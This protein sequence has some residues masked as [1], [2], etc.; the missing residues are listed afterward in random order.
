MTP[1][2]PARNRDWMAKRRML[3]SNMRG[4]TMRSCPTSISA[5][6][7]VMSCALRGVAEEGSI[8]LL[9]EEG[10][11]QRQHGQHEGGTQQVWHAEQAQLGVGGFDDDHCRGEQEKLQPIGQQ[12]HAQGGGRR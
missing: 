7:R 10:G 6:I 5:A 3:V 2:M 12:P 1:A 11:K 8:S 9:K 4:T